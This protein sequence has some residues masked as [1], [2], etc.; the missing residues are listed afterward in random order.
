LQWIVGNMHL[1]ASPYLFVSVHIFKNHRMGFDKI[2]YL[3][4]FSDTSLVRVKS[5]KITDALCA[6]P[7]TS[8]IISKHVSKFGT[9]CTDERITCFMPSSLSASLVL[10]KYLKIMGAKVPELLASSYPI[11]VDILTNRFQLKCISSTTQTCSEISHLTRWF[12][13]RTTVRE[14]FPWGHGRHWCLLAD[15]LPQCHGGHWCLMEALTSLPLPSD[16]WL[17][18]HA[19]TTR[20]RVA[21]KLHGSVSAMPHEHRK[22]FQWLWHFRVV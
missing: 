19:T 9:H 18:F 6:I 16:A 21:Y 2:L 5:D 15:P 8:S 13:Q 14:R 4:K 7:R 20:S 17:C 1:L 10:F 3:L 22:A 12:P 11:N